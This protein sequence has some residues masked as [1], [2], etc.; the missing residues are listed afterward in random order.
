VS[1]HHGGD[2]GIGH[3]IHAGQVCVVDGSELAAAKLERELTN[4]PGTGIIRHVDAGCE[5]LERSP[6][7]AASA[8]PCG[9]S[10]VSFMSPF[11]SR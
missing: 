6:P 7:S 9:S 3:S 1:I 8:S 11:W 2:V 4:D 10:A 5:R